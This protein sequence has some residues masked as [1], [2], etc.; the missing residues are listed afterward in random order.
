MTGVLNKDNRPNCL[1]IDEIDG[2]G[3]PAIQV[4]NFFSCLEVDFLLSEKYCDIIFII[5]LI[6]FKF[7]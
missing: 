3:A 1:I 4:V 7:G 5:I 2:A 6:I